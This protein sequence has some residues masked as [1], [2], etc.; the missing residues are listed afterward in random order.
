[1]DVV[2]VGAGLSGL[3]AACHLAGRGHDV[4]VVERDAMP[5]GRAGRLERDGYRFDTGPTVLTMPSLLE[6]T[7]AAAGVDMADMLTLRPVDPMYRADF[8]DGSVIHV[9]HGREAMT[10]E[11]RTTC[12]PR[13]AAA[14]DRFVRLAHRAVRGRDAAL[15]RPQLRL[16]LS[17]SPARSA[18]RCVCCVS[19]GC[20]AWRRRWTASSPTSGCGGCSASRRCTPGWRRTRRSPSSASSRTWTPSAASTSPRAACTPCRRRW[21]RP[22]PRPGP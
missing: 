19:A 6:Q 3:S 2:V 21:P 22:P 15:H 5:G 17:T 18:R 7:F 4:T 11:I 12:G 9:R 10:E 1:M 20:G 14:F 13:E 8:A 16:R